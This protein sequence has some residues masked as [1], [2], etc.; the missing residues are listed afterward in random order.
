MSIFMPFP[1]YSGSERFSRAGWFF[2]IFLQKIAFT[3]DTM[4]A[5]RA[6]MKKD[7]WMQVAEA[8]ERDLYVNLLKRNVSQLWVCSPN[9]I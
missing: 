8:F 5:S 1:S 9:N 6:Q 7:G 2:N 4:V 3:G